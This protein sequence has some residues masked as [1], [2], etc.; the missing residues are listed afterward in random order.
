LEIKYEF[1]QTKYFFLSVLALR[2][3]HKTTFAW[4]GLF[5]LKKLKIFFS[6]NF[7]FRV[8]LLK[9][10]SSCFFVLIFCRRCYYLKQSQFRKMTKFILSRQSM[11]KRVIMGCKQ[12]EVADNSIILSTQNINWNI[13]YIAI[14]SF[15]TNI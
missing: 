7:F 8:A 1:R 6:T 4:R 10:K 3:R 13:I 5:S 14:K 2:R 15:W 9:K 12:F 11:S